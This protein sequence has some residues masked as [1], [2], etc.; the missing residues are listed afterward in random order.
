MDFGV[1][2]LLI[3]IAIPVIII[4]GRAAYDN[5]K[6][7][8]DQI[9]FDTQK[10]VQQIIDALRS[11]NCSIEELT[12]DPLSSYETE[13]AADIEVLL[14]GGGGFIDAIRHFWVGHASWGVQVYVYELGN[15]RHVTLVAAGLEGWSAAAAIFNVGGRDFP[16]L[17]LSKDY[18]DRIAQALA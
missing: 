12:S 1:V 18:R 9:E 7:D 2:I 14:T 6:L 11:F 17:T 8:Y 16:S 10:T 13:E 5:A 4:V 3:L 15:K